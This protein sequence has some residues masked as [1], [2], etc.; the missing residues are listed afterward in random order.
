MCVSW[1]NIYIREKDVRF[2]AAVKTQGSYEDR[3]RAY[4]LCNES[5]KRTKVDIDSRHEDGQGIE[6]F[7][8]RAPQTVE[9]ARICNTCFQERRFSA[10]TLYCSAC[11]TEI[12]DRA[13]CSYSVEKKEA[14]VRGRFSFELVSQHVV[15]GLL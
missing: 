11:D 1:Q 2:I 7:K 10:A 9:S 4:V 5:V 14:V 12:R 13:L 6:P 8:D 3:I 15:P